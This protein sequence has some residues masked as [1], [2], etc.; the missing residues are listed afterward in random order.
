MG[1]RLTQLAATGAIV[2]SDASIHPLIEGSRAVIAVNSGVGS[3]AIA[4][5]KPI[6]LF[7]AADYDCV[8]HRVRCE[9]DFARLTTPRESPTIKVLQLT[10]AH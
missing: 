1:A 3:E 7:G 5:L 6:Y 4:H 2:L 9:E 10:L 8:A